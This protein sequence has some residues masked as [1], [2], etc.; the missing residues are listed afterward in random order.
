MGAP[1]DTHR[2]S[3]HMKFRRLGA[4]LVLILFVFAA[5]AA[6]AAR[7]E[8]ASYGG[9]QGDRIR[10]DERYRR[11]LVHDRTHDLIDLV[12]EA[13]RRDRLNN[14]ESD[15]LLDRL[16]KINDAAHKDRF[17]TLDEFRRRMDDLD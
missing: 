8:D 2:E 6:S 13:H 14:R 5:A 9:R 4:G 16:E 7:R 10:Y 17:F 11:D 1:E 12:R 3:R 15:R